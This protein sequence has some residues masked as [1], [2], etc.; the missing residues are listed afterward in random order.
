MFSSIWIPPVPIDATIWHGREPL[1][2]ELPLLWEAHSVNMLETHLRFQICADMCIHKFSF[3]STLFFPPLSSEAMLWWANPE[4]CA[5]IHVHRSI[6]CWSPKIQNCF[7]H[8]GLSFHQL[9]HAIFP[10]VSTI[11]NYYKK[12]SPAQ[13]KAGQVGLPLGMRNV[14]STKCTGHLLHPGEGKEPLDSSKGCFEFSS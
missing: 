2:G 10:D 12:K 1:M 3:S 6:I 13:V 9:S 7:F 11:H 8:L 14:V 5:P 4:G